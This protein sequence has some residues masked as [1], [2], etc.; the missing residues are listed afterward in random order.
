MAHLAPS[1]C[2]TITAFELPNGGGVQLWFA[3]Y[4]LANTE[5]C[6]VVFILLFKTFFYPFAAGLSFIL[7]PHHHSLKAIPESCF[8]CNAWIECSL[9]EP[10]D[11][12][13][14]AITPVFAHSCG[15]LLFWKALPAQG[16]LPG[17]MWRFT[18]SRTQWGN[19]E[20]G[21]HVHDQQHC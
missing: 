14:R 6:W 3:R 10:C 11:T 19:A 1:D 15:W 7:A 18:D 13:I 2:M 17:F 4:G 5:W 8:H 20:A 16:W 9:I 12:S 21:F